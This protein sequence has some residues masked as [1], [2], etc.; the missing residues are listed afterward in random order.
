MRLLL[1]KEYEI[2]YTSYEQD[3]AKSNVVSVVQ[4]NKAQGGIK[5]DSE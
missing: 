1:G 2:V 5:R 3:A 4:P